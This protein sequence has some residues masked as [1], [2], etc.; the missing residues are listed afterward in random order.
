MKEREK[1][2]KKIQKSQIEGAEDDELQD[3][4][5]DDE[6]FEF[7]RKKRLQEL[8]EQSKK[9]R[10]GTLIEINEPSY[11]EEVTNQPEDVHVVVFL[12]KARFL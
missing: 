1:L 4:L 9:A 2:T 8:K 5:N 6:A 3:L 12:H 11:K 7:Y 10:F